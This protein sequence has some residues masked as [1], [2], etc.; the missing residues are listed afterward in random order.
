MW[1]VS[2]LPTQHP[3]LIAP[4]D[5]SMCRGLS[6]ACTQLK[7]RPPVTLSMV[8]NTDVWV[9]NIKL[10]NSSLEIEMTVCLTN[11]PSPHNT[12]THLHAESILALVEAGKL[13]L[14]PAAAAG[15]ATDD[16]SGDIKGAFP[17]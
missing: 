11:A 2:P 4:L 6:A 17:L 15:I 13:K 9:K 1:A 16:G 8:S 3:R 7:K 5:V 12:N 10:A 14:S